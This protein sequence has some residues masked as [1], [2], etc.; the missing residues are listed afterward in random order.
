MG[1]EVRGEVEGCNDDESRYIV[2]NHYCVTVLSL[3][4][5]GFEVDEEF[6]RDPLFGSYGPV[7]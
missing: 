7:I 6:S 1:G 3:I 4:W 5:K 2:Q